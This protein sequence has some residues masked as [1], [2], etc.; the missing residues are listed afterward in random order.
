MQDTQQEAVCPNCKEKLASFERTLYVL[1]LIVLGLEKTVR[2]L[3][4]K[5]N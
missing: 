2:A 1:G 3:E 4:Q 5:L